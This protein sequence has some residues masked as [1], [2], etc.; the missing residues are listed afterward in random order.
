MIVVTE[1]DGNSS[2]F[3]DAVMLATRVFDQV[4]TPYLVL[5]D[6][7]GS[8]RA[9]ISL[10]NMVITDY[11]TTPPLTIHANQS[12]KLWFRSFAMNI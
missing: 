4:A 8:P 2:D 12:M 7:D 11:S 3:D 5:H 9:L 6:E 10:S 1:L